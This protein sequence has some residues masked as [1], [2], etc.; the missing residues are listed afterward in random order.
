MK[1]KCVVSLIFL[2]L[3]MTSC[4]Q[5]HTT[6]EAE[7]I[8]TDNQFQYLIQRERYYNVF[9]AQNSFPNASSSL[10]S[11]WSLLNIKA[12]KGVSKQFYFEYDDENNKLVPI[13]EDV[14]ETFT[15]ERIDKECYGLTIYLIVED[16]NKWNETNLRLIGSFEWSRSLPKALQHQSYAFLGAHAHAGHVSFL[17]D[18]GTLEGTLMPAPAFHGRG[19]GWESREVET[20]PVHGTFSVRAYQQ[21]KVDVSEKN[22]AYVIPFDMDSTSSYRVSFEQGFTTI[23]NVKP[24]S[25]VYIQLP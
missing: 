13:K 25:T 22:F 2:C 23:K 5:A 19:F 9:E 1:H 3:F 17:D 8:S 14:F 21:G 24:L 18:I 4:S 20:V 6:D 11:N 16:N 7:I 15:K 12:S 10:K